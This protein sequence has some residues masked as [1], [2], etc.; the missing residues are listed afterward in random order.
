ML[1]LTQA[2]GCSG[3]LLF[4]LFLRFLWWFRS[5]PFTKNNGC[6]SSLCI[7]AQVGALV[8]LQCLSQGLEHGMLFCCLIQT[9]FPPL[10]GNE[11][12]WTGLGRP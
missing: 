9:P 6:I 1:E 4:C 8:Q 12:G 10:E 11:Y 7:R 3:W 2:K 5:A